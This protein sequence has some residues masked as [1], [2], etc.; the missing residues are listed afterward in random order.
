[1]GNA[2]SGNC[3]FFKSTFS[4]AILCWEY[5]HDLLPDTSNA[6]PVD[7]NPPSVGEREPPRPTV[8]KINNAI[9]QPKTKHFNEIFNLGRVFGEGSSGAVFL[10]VEKATSRQYACKVIEKANLTRTEHVKALVGEIQIMRHLEGNPNVASIQD[11][12][13]D[14]EAV[15]IVMELCRGGELFDRMKKRGRCTETE[16]AELIRTIVT[17]VQSL[18][19]S[20]VMHKDL[21]PDNFL[22]LNEEQNSP[23]KVIDFGLSTFFKPGEKL[24]E[25][26]GTPFYIAPEVLK[27]HYGP[28]ADIWS[29]GVILYILLSGTPPFWAE[30]KEMIYQ[31]VLH[32]GLDLSSDPWPVIS[33]MLR[34]W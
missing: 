33:E 15:Y 2:C 19:S 9:L 7:E 25:P 30:T 23:L 20:G 28:E 31:T 29:A 13:E 14:S 21:K 22:F 17:V 8:M 4:D 12:Y 3:S 6:E 1:M 27:K 10:C 11:A 5:D 26:A 16:A 34:I 24:S 32:E 18:H